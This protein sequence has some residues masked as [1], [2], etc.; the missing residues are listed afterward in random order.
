MTPDTFF[1]LMRQDRG[2]HAEMRLRHQMGFLYRDVDFTN[3]RVLDIGGG[4]GLHS[5]F[6]IAKG[7]AYATLIEPEGDGGHNTMI[8]TFNRYRQ[9]LATSRAELIQ[10]TLQNFT[11]PG[12]GFDVVLIQ[13]AIN[14][15]DEAACIMLRQS[16]ESRAIYT[17]IF[18]KIASLIARGGHLILSD[19]SS[20]NLFPAL[21]MRNPIDR[22]IEWHK[23]QPPSVWATLAR[24]HGLERKSLRWSTPAR[25]GSIGKVVFGNA[26]ASWFFTSHFVLTMSKGRV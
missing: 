6:A 5:F 25:L 16:S 8:A 23:H 17:A 4:I 1:Q 24:E 26:P 15:F 21:G 3:A 13:D 18:A 12:S 20:R 9:S 11:P 14:H 10:T 19:C 7:A 2:P 22:A